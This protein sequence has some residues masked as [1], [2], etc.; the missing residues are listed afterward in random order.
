MPLVEAD[1]VVEDGSGLA[2]ANS[3]GTLAEAAEY[4]RL[5][6][7]TLWAAATENDR[8]A[9]LIAAT[10]YVC[11]RYLYIGVL[12]VRSPTPQSLEF[13]RVSEDGS[14]LY[15]ARGID[16]SGSV[17]AVIKQVTFEYALRALSG[18]LLPDPTVPD[19]A[20]RFV[21]LERKKLG[22]LEK[23]LRFAAGKPLT[24]L[25]KYPK[26]DRMLRMSGLVTGAGD[27]VIRA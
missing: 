1:L 25:R 15:D 3:F 12:E 2:N 14:A 11:Q 13:P 27:G 4:H 20:G 18:E 22:P 10:Q 16:I 26:A 23:E 24:L 6:D 9:A 7:N 5:L 17:P 19:A 21:T 8:V